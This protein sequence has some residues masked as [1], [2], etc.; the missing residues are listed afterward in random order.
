MEGKGKKGKL[1]LG[2]ALKV[3]LGSGLVFGGAYVI[4]RL[5]EKQDTEASLS[6]L[7]QMLSE[8]AETEG[9]SGSDKNN[10]Q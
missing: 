4:S 8:L 6:R 2:N 3:T 7:E 5:G 9:K 1:Y 10:N